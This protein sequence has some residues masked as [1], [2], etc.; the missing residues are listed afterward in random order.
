MD[1]KSN[2][3]LLLLVCHVDMAENLGAECVI[4]QK[5]ME[6]QGLVLASAIPCYS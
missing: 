3:Q 6:T 1:Q 4:T 5:A 2:R